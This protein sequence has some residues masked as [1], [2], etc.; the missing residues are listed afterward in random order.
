MAVVAVMAVMA[1]VAVVAVVAVMAV[2]AVV[3]VVAVMAAVIAIHPREL[4]SGRHRPCVRIGARGL[5][6]IG[7]RRC[8]EQRRG[9]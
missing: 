5:P 7:I 4:G 8:S 1:V 6:I 2:V 9:Q 3:A